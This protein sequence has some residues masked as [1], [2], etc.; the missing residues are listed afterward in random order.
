MAIV[1]LFF[2][3]GKNHLMLPI[4]KPY[5][6]VYLI[7]LPYIIVIL[8]IHIEIWGWQR[9]KKIL[10][11]HTWIIITLPAS[12]LKILCLIQ[13]VEFMILKISYDVNKTH[14][15][16]YFFRYS[17]VEHI[18][19]VCR[20]T[21]WIYLLHFIS[22]WFCLKMWKISVKVSNGDRLCRVL[23]AKPGAVSF[24]LFSGS[25]P[26]NKLASEWCLVLSWNEIPEVVQI[27]KEWANS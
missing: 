16:T 5:I 26:W 1:A 8:M 3:L 7:R 11:T 10:K 15:K 12:R 4:L 18:Q 13:C 6:K 9:K 14:L 24:T 17:I 27:A 25:V 23:G 22:D 19:L 2:N 20:N 21:F